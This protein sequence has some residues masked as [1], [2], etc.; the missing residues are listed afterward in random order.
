ML[1]VQARERVLSQF[2]SRISLLELTFFSCCTEKESVEVCRVHFVNVDRLA[3]FIFFMG[4][5]A[6]I[7]ADEMGLGKTVQ[8]GNFLL[9]YHYLNLR[10][11]I[12]NSLLGGYILKSAETLGQRPWAPP[13]CL[14]G[15]SSGKLGERT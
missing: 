8:V 7:L 2:L 4:L 10:I 11:Y 14:S 5:S 3:V 15:F 1:R 12:Y 13:N 6:A 9:Y